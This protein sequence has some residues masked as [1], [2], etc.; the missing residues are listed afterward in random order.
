MIDDVILGEGGSLAVRSAEHGGLCLVLQDYRS[1]P[2]DPPLR[3]NRHEARRLAE[4]LLQFA[5]GNRP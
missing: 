2:V 4:I 1:R 5:G 3:I